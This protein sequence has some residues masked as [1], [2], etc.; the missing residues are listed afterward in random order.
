MPPRRASASTSY[1]SIYLY[2][3]NGSTYYGTLEAAANYSDGTVSYLV[4]VQAWG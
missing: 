1:Q 3:G 2:Q 4:E